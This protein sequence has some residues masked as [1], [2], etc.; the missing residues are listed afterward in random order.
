MME[1]PSNIVESSCKT[2]KL[3]H[4]NRNVFRV[5]HVLAGQRVL[6][7]KWDF[8]IKHNRDGS[9]R[10]YK[11]LWVVRG[12]DIRVGMYFDKERLYVMWVAP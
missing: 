3:W 4:E 12:F 6:N 2:G 9:I 1:P 8:T 7:T 10:K 11:A 5:V